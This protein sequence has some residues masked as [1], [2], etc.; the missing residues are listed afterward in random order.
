[1][2]RKSLEK[3]EKYAILGEDPAKGQ[4]KKAW[5][6]EIDSYNKIDPKEYFITTGEATVKI[7][8][9]INDLENLT[10]EAKKLKKQLIKTK[11]ES[12][13]LETCWESS[14]LIVKKKE[15]RSRA[16]KNPGENQK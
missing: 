15:K 16:K 5:I 4:S 2:S 6:V 8:V 14:N 3:N 11:G 10:K 13:Y 12:D 1:M 9:L 7:D